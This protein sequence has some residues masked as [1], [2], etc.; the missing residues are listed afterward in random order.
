[1]LTLTFSAKHSCASLLPLR[2]AGVAV[3]SLVTLNSSQ[4]TYQSHCCPVS[5]S[6]DLGVSVDAA[7][8]FDYHVSG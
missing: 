7:L 6:F 8:F 1:M 4:I 5:F 2:A 3:D